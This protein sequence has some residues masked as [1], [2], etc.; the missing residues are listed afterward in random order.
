MSEI[1]IVCDVFECSMFS[2]LAKDFPFSNTFL[3]FDFNPYCV[4]VSTL[5][6]IHPPVQDTIK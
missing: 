6:E 1:G 2:P 3:P 5:L 4:H